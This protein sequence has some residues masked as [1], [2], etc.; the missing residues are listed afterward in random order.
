MINALRIKPQVIIT[1]TGMKLSIE[2]F[3]PGG[4][5]GSLEIEHAGQV[6]RFLFNGIGELIHM[7][8]RA[9][10][11]NERIVTVGAKLVDAPLTDPSEIYK[12]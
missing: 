4:S 2:T 12:D 10:E 1:T 3:E 5:A 8:L 9:P 6:T 7:R 11:E